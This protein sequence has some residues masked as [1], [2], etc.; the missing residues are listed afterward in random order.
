[1]FNAYQHYDA[2][3]VFWVVPFQPRSM[4]PYPNTR[5]E[6]QQVVGE[7]NQ[8]KQHKCRDH[9]SKSIRNKHVTSCDRLYKKKKKTRKTPHKTLMITPKTMLP[10]TYSLSH[11]T[12]QV[13]FRIMLM[14]HERKNSEGRIAG[15]EYNLRT[16]N[17]D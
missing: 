6:D 1:M 13:L 15:L 17:S 8:G 11:N 14:I 9:H 16:N 5:E 12:S 4:S 7:S 2:E 3:K 10:I